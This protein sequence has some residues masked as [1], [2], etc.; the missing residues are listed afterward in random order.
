MGYT[1]VV[2]DEHDHQAILGSYD[3]LAECQKFW[4]DY[5]TR[6]DNHGYDIYFE[7]RDPEG[8]AIDGVQF[9]K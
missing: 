5:T 2:F 6:E 9:N 3:T 1:I 8:Y 7:M 4:D